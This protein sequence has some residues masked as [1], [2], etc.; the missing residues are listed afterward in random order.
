MNRGERATS[1]GASWHAP[2]SPTSRRN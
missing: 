1:W 2:R